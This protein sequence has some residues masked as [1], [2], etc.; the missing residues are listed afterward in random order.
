MNI[1]SIMKSRPFVGA[2]VCMLCFSLSGCATI[3]TGVNQKVSFLSD[4]TGATL[5][6]NGKEYTTPCKVKLPRNKFHVGA[7][8]KDSYDTAEFTLRRKNNG[9]TA[10]NVAWFAL[11]PVGILIGMV[12]MS[13]D[14]SSGAA[15]WLD[16]KNVFVTLTPT[17]PGRATSLEL[18]N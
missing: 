6:I 11:A 3:F 15:F 18:K 1:R 12:G 10:V 14:A 7:F 4:P 13:I 5:K 9:T 16:S 17:A 8:S 2:L